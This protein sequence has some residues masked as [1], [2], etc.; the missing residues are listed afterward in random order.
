M[1]WLEFYFFSIIKS[2]E[3]G[4]KWHW[5]WDGATW[6]YPFSDKW[7][8]LRCERYSERSSWFSWNFTRHGENGDIISA[9]HSSCLFFSSTLSWN[10]WLKLMHEYRLGTTPARPPPSHTPRLN[11]KR[12][13][14]NKLAINYLYSNFRG[15]SGSPFEQALLIKFQISVFFSLSGKDDT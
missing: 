11:L 5:Y 10:S 4:R 2:E 12:M 9:S 1:S 14:P 8:H 15:I 7:R 3:A 6:G 13:W